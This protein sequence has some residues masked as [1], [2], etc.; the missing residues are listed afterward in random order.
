MIQPGNLVVWDSSLSTRDNHVMIVISVIDTG[1]KRFGVIY[2]NWFLCQLLT[3]EGSIVEKYHFLL[4][5]IL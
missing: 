1:P 3:H 5:K 4:K 2:K